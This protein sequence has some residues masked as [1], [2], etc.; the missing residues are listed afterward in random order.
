MSVHRIIY[1]RMHDELVQAPII[2]DNAPTCLG[3]AADYIISL[4][5]PPGPLSLCPV[6]PQQEGYER[7]VP[8]KGAPRALAWF[9]RQR[10]DEAIIR[11]VSA[12]SKYVVGNIQNKDRAYSIRNLIRTAP[13]NVDE[14]LRT[15]SGP[16]PA[17]I[18]VYQRG[19]EP[20]DYSDASGTRFHP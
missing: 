20:F 17:R 11:A 4:V 3:S 14:S 19:G 13:G 7:T 9:E 6:V 15:P 16:R 18:T 10:K 8:A 12:T 5:S 2:L 1:I